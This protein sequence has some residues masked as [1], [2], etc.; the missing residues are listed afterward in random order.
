MICFHV[1]INFC[2]AHSGQMISA[3]SV[4]KPRPTS[5]VLHMAQMKQS[6]CQWRSSKEIN[7]VPPIPTTEQ[8]R[9]KHSYFILQL[10]ARHNN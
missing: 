1:H 6:L 10:Q 3:P 7:R 2:L 9:K 8:E 4:I 5:E